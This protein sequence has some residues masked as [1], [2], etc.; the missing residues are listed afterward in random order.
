MSHTT[1]RKNN[2]YY[3]FPQKAIIVIETVIILF[4]NEPAENYKFIGFAIRNARIDIQI[5]I[6]K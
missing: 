1:S 4:Q 2:Y 3:Y 5:Y 6:S